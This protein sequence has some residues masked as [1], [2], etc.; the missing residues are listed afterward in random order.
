ME[1]IHSGSEGLWVA[2]KWVAISQWK[3]ILFC[4]NET[5]DWNHNL[6][7]AILEELNWSYYLKERCKRLFDCAIWSFF[8]CKKNK[9]PFAQL[10]YCQRYKTPHLHHQAYRQKA[11]Y[12]K[13]ISLTIQS[14]KQ[15][16]P[17]ATQRELFFISNARFLYTSATAARTVIPIS[18]RF[19]ANGN[20]L[21]CCSFLNK[22]V[23]KAR[24]MLMWLSSTAVFPLYSLCRG[25]T[26]TLPRV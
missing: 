2:G 3:G 8:N 11:Q 12:F 26:L 6:L 22:N 19:V 7:G 25:N 20:T 9:E 16:F 14:W 10:L 18:R 13:C 4:A 23:A 21:L 15:L 24:Q 1:L 17:I 5:R